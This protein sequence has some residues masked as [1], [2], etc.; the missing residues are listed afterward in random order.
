MLDEQMIVPLSL[1]ELQNS[2]PLLA[3]AEDPVDPEIEH[4]EFYTVLFGTMLF[5]FVMAACN[6]KFKPKVGHQ[7]SFT[8]ILGVVIALFLWLAFGDTR[9]EI[10]R[11]N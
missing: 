11:F 1:E 9:Q 5:F 3:A 8:I 10:Y 6:E 4:M 7:T 2:R